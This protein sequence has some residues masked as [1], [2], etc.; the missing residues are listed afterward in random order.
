MKCPFFKRS[1]AF[2]ATAAVAAA[3]LLC[4]PVCALAPRST[5]QN[6]EAAEQFMLVS[7]LND[8]FVVQGP[9]N[10][11][12]TVMSLREV[13][14]AAAERVLFEIQR[15]DL[16]NKLRRLVETLQEFRKS[17]DGMFQYSRA[18]TA[19]PGENYFAFLDLL[20]SSFVRMRLVRVQENIHEQI[21]KNETLR[22][23]C[24][25]ANVITSDETD[26]VYDFLDKPHKLNGALMQTHGVFHKKVYGPATLDEANLRFEALV[27]LFRREPKTYAHRLL[28]RELDVHHV[29]KLE[30]V[31]DVG[32][33]LNDSELK[34][35]LIEAF[36]SMK[37]RF[38]F[39]GENREVLRFERGTA[40]SRLFEDL[41]R[42][43]VLS[44]SGELNLRE[45]EL[46]ISH[47]EDL[48]WL[49]IL[50]LKN[51]FP[52]VVLK[53]RKMRRMDVSEIRMLETYFERV[54]IP[55][56]HQW[57][58]FIE[59][60][61]KVRDWEPIEAEYANGIKESSSLPEILIKG[62]YLLQHPN[63]AREGTIRVLP[64]KGIQTAS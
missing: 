11:R 41:V 16:E 42:R 17:R 8:I 58:G 64:G 63:R 2:P 19:R 12:L 35:A 33:I 53:I 59:V 48:K 61:R 52:S 23:V 45:K 55:K 36:Q 18:E 30:R 6:R 4:L 62:V 28:I 21:T 5:L 7:R 3:M 37:N 57:L 1:T 27:P 46:L 54:I 32:E 13:L 56:L 10:D 50:A 22:Q 14:Q 51:M 34:K 60:I 15:E 29:K 40:E 43:G 24:L 9:L 20:E 39:V 49:N 31:R 44:P 47:K 25:R 26:L 38:D